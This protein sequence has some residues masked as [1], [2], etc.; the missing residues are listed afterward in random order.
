MIISIDAEKFIDKIQYSF[1]IKALKKMRI[2]RSYLKIIK[3]TSDKTYSQY[4]IE[5][6]NPETISSEAKN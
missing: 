2:K 1:T 3:D 4:Y 5:W 6:E